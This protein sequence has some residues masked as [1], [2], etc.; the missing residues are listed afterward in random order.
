M[1]PF[2]LIKK[3]SMATLN[4]QQNIQQSS[5]CKNFYFHDSTPLWNAISAPNGYDPFSGVGFNPSDIVLA[6]CYIDITLPDLSIVRITFDISDYDLTRL[7]DT[8]TNLIQRTISYSD[9]GFGTNLADG[10]YKFDYRVYDISG[11]VYISSCYIVQDCQSCCCLDTKL[12]KIKYCNDCKDKYSNDI[13][14]LYDLYLKRDSARL[15]AS[16]GDYEGAQEALNFI[17]DECNIKSCDSCN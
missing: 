8:G 14:T 2:L 17:L 1:S 5:D 11:L 12:A 7:E 4:L 6:L 16:C 3:E 13:R 15:L 9:L 10:I